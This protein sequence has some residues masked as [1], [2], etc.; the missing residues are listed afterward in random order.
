MKTHKKKQSLVQTGR[1]ITR[2]KEK[3]YESEGQN[4]SLKPNLRVGGEEQVSNE[5]GGNEDIN[6]EQVEDEQAGNE[7]GGNED[8]NEERAGN[9]AGGNE[10][11]NEE[12]VEEEQVSNEDINEEQV[13]QEEGYDEELIG[14]ETAKVMPPVLNEI[15]KEPNRETCNVSPLMEDFYKGCQETD[16][17]KTQ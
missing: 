4:K 8:T 10:N 17:N 14:D 3:A 2:R 5:A 12:Q 13:E 1:K 15:A 16:M 11:T 9:E 6:E 7:A